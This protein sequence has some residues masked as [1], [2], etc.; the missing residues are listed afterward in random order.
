VCP[1][2]TTITGQ[3]GGIGWSDGAEQRYGR[4]RLEN[5]I[6]SELVNLAVPMRTEYYLDAATG[7]VPNADDACSTGITLSLG[8]FTNN[9]SAGETCVVENGSPG[10]SGAA[11]AAAGPAGQRYREPPVAGDF[12]LWLQ[13]P[14]EG[15]DGSTTIT[16]DVPAW[17]TF[18]W[19]AALPGFEN[20]A[21][22]A[23]FGIYRGED[24]RIYLR[25][26][27]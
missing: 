4:V 24:R 7:F 19:D 15:N 27:Y 17:L 20:P 23:T 13:A 3:G 22:T 18:D 21:G 11:C 5:A 2:G 6:G 14:G 8:G 25:E 26:L 12:N 1:T 9:L 16:A 10:Q